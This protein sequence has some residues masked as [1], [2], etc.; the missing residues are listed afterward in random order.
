[1]S[2]NSVPAVKE[3]RHKSFSWSRVL[4]PLLIAGILFALRSQIGSALAPFLYAVLLAY[5]L[6]PIVRLLEKHGFSRG[7]AIAAIYLLLLLALVLLSLYVIPTVYAQINSL[8]RHLPAFSVRAQELLFDLI[9]QY[10][11]IDLPPAIVDAIEANLQR[12]QG[13]LIALFNLIGQFILGLVNSIV[14]II[15]VPILTFYMLKDMETIQQSLLALV[16]TAYRPGVLGVLGKISNKLGAWIRGQVSIG[17]ITGG[18]MFLGMKL[19]GMDYALVLGILVA[20]FNFIPYFGAIIG[21]TPA[22]LL[23]LLRSP[24]LGLK[25]LIVQVVVQ[26]I[27]SS[28]LVPQI[29]GKELGV[30]PL[31]IIFALL[32]GSQF[33]GVLG[34]VLAAP[35]ASIV[36]DLI[37]DR[38]SNRQ[39][40]SSEV[41]DS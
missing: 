36:L 20:I 4:L 23:G 9:D 29:L 3:S 31:L 10:E 41:A 17:L 14:I 19:V 1:M 2:L 40:P 13:T 21:A 33:G 32:L 35:V 18:L 15:L 12:I 39:E 30:H 34:M 16:P 28:V 38:L 6:V 8:V 37:N 7:W 22:V 5:L 27:E 24:A 25:V 11:R 26:Q